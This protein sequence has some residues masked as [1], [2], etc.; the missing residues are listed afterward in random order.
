MTH[1]K[2]SAD[3]RIGKKTDGGWNVCAADIYKPKEYGLVY[4]YG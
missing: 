1:L 2:C 3:V 4:S